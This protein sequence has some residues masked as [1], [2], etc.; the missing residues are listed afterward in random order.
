MSSLASQVLLPHVPQSSGHVAAVSSPLH[1]PSPHTAGA[2]APPPAVPLLP[3]VAPPLP[4]SVPPLPLT[5]PP[6]PPTPASVEV[7]GMTTSITTG[8][9]PTAA[10]TR[11][12]AMLAQV[13]GCLARFAAD[14]R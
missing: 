1:V 8:P 14:V 3:P 7:P 9:Q 4:P 11:T 5:A 12:N 2:V 6:L 13:R 10:A